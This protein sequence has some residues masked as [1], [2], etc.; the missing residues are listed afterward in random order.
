MTTR[1]ARQTRVR[2]RSQCSGPEFHGAPAHS[3]AS[4]S[5]PKRNGSGVGAQGDRNRR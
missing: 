3:P 2:Q 1:S 5:V 4:R